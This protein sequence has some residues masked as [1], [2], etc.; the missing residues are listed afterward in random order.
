MGKIIL[1]VLVL[2]LLTT[3]FFLYSCQ[4]SQATDL[5]AGI[6]AQTVDK[7]SLTSDKTSALA[8]FSI[9]LFKES[10]DGNKNTLISPVSVLYALAMTA[11]G[12]HGNTLAQAEDV[13]GLP[14]DTLN[15]YLHTYIESLPYG[16]KYKVSLANSIWL[17]EDGDF[18]VKQDFLQKNADYYGAGVYKAPFDDSTLKEINKWV[19]DNTDGMIEKI[20]DNISDDAVMYLI[21][22]LA[23]DA[24][25]Q[26]T[27]KEHQI[28]DGKFTAEDGTKCDIKLMHSAESL[29][30]EDEKAAGF[31][32]HYKDSK[33]AFVALLPNEDI[34][35]SEY[36]AGLDAMHL[37][38][39]IDSP[40][41]VPVN[42]ALPKFES[43][44]DIELSD[45]L[46]TMGMTDAFDFDSAD[47]SALGSHKKGEL[48]I[49]R[50]LHKTYVSVTEQGTRAGAATAVELLN[51][52]AGPRETNTVVLDRPFLYMIIDCENSLPLFVGAVTDI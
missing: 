2:A 38:E 45:V 17:K 52:S 18:E 35:L 19:E 28:R 8:D 21:N 40:Q 11:N 27:Y 10:F 47:F 14:R 32:K 9:K 33:Y 48:A 6:K 5:M 51:G 22:A 34:T 26:T 23:F 24:E 29:Y 43:E 49:G 46:K 4:K 42:A 7:V 1:I 13:M 37:W 20:L 15:S 12:M 39:L 30:L 36:V 25:W 50:V 3:P 16:E 31:I 41:R 44:Y